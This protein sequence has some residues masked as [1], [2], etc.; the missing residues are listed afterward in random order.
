MSV[1]A[2]EAPED[3]LSIEDQIN[4]LG[5]EDQLKKLTDSVDCGEGTPEAVEGDDKENES[6]EIEPVAWGLIGS[7]ELCPSEVVVESNNFHSPVGTEGKLNWFNWASID[8]D[9][10]NDSISFNISTSDPR[11]SSLN[12]KVFRG[13]DGKLHSS[14]HQQEYE[15]HPPNN[16]SGLNP[17]T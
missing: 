1:P 2:Q 15:I 10:Q 13:S 8:F 7:D 17:H 3:N 5:I 14:S 9:E 6:E 11:G 16:P 4:G 12:V